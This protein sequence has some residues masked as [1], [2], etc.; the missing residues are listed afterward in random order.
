MNLPIRVLPGHLRH[1][2]LK[3]RYIADLGDPLVAITRDPNFHFMDFRRQR[4]PDLDRAAGERRRDLS[5]IRGG[6]KTETVTNTQAASE[7]SKE[8]FHR[9]GNWD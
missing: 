2:R 4:S 3:L 9:A 5:R 6:E 8:R 7:E 1:R